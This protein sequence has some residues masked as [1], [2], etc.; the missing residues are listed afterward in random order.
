MT[1]MAKMS[2]ILR[3]MLFDF[4]GAK[5]RKMREISTF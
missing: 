4:D 5:I 2:I 3:L 1:E